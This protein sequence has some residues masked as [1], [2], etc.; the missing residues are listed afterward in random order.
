MI[1]EQGVVNILKARQQEDINQR[2][3]K[4]MHAINTRE[5]PVPRAFPSIF[6]FRITQQRKSFPTVQKKEK[7]RQ[8][9]D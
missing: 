3:E 7:R 5:C 6:L 4:L 8:V 2:K 1:Y 9:S